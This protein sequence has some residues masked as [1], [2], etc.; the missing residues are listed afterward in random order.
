M[1]NLDS[2]NSLNESIEDSHFQKIRK[3]L[4]Y[5]L[6]TSF[7]LFVGIA[8]GITLAGQSQDTRKKASTQII[9]DQATQKQLTVYKSSGFGY[10]VTF[11][12]NI[13][14]TT[15]DLS[16]D[17]QEITFSLRELGPAIVKVSSLPL[18]E[19]DTSL[20][21]LVNSVVSEMASDPKVRLSNVE[22]IT[23]SSREYY[24]FTFRESF[25]NIESEYYQYLALEFPWYYL[26]ETKYSQLEPAQRLTETLV[27]SVSFSGNSGTSVQGISD[28]IVGKSLNTSQVADL[29]KPSVVSIIHIYCAKATTSKQLTF[30]KHSYDLCGASKGTG[31][32]ISSDGHIGTNGHVVKLYPEDTLVNSLS[33]ISGQFPTELVQEITAGQEGKKISTTQAQSVL[34]RAS[35]DPPAF[36]S[37]LQHSYRLIEGKTLDIDEVSSRYFVNLGNEVLPIDWEK[38]RNGQLFVSPPVSNA[39]REAT[40]VDFNYPNQRSLDSVLRNNVPVGSDVA[41]LKVKSSQDLS[42]PSLRVTLSSSMREGE[43]VIVIGYPTLVEGAQDVRSPV[44]FA[45]STSP[46]ITRGIVSSVKTDQVGSTLIQTDASIEHGNSGGPAFNE[47]GE[48]IGVA[49]YVQPSQSGN[50]NFLRSTEDLLALV[51]KNNVDVGKSNSYDSWVSGLTNFWTGRFKVAIPFFE[52]A[53]SLYPVSPVFEQYVQKS[54]NERGGGFELNVSL[55]AAVFLVLAG[56]A[57][58]AITAL[59]I[60]PSKVKNLLKV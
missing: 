32:I 31:F 53:N 7:L 38:A 21:V 15:S 17:N 10:Q 60:F 24:K 43:P 28:E 37:L 25:L 1:E 54:Q 18:K 6:S 44:G 4:L 3:K 5:V 9:I 34:S 2:L 46:T 27:D 42:F 36:N 12:P 59:F 39:V 26:I 57:G 41:I 48:V 14:D 11:D 58:G 20:D 50:Y 22:K 13:W 52:K 16:Q 55:P 23:R 40:L 35:Q 8:V 56:A 33:D 49:T 30:L 29:A 51:S 45:S 19:S 47:R